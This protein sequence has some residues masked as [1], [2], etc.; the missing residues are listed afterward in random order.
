MLGPNGVGARSLD[1]TDVAALAT[2]IL[3]GHQLFRVA[4]LTRSH[5][6]SQMGAPVSSFA[7]FT[8][9]P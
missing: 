3:A 8:P 2:A 4:A 6:A 7:T 9:N 1:G 5:D